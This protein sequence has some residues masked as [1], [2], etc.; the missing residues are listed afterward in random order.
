MNVTRR[1]LIVAGG[2]GAATVSVFVVNALLARAWDLQTFGRFSAVWI[3]GNALAPVFQ[4]GIPSAL[5][6]FFPRHDSRGR[7]RLLGMA[8]ASLLLA[9]AVFALV[10]S[11]AG[12]ALAP[13]LG[14]EQTLTSGLIVSFLPYAFCLVAAGQTDSALI[15][16]GAPVMQATIGGAHALSLIA[17][18]G[19][20]CQVGLAVEEVL[21]LA[22][23]TGLARLGVCY[24]TLILIIGVP[25]GSA[26]QE[27]RS[28]FRYAWTIGTGDAMGSLSRNVD[29]AVVLSLF[30]A[31][32][33]GLYHVGAIEVPVS[34]LLSAVVAVVLPEVSRLAAEGE[35]TRV[36][37][38]FRRAVGQLAMLI[39]PLFCYL[40]VFAENIFAVYLPKAFAES[41][42]VF[43]L[44]LLALPLRCAIY[45]P[46]LV[47][48][49]H[50][51]WALKGA[52]F[53][54]VTNV[55]LSI[56]FVVVL[57]DHA[58]ELAL[59]GPAA[60]TVTA[61]YLQV[62]ALVIATSIALGS[63]VRAMLPGRRLLRT[64]GVAV[65]SAFT[66]SVLLQSWQTHALTVVAIS[67]G[68]FSLLYCGGLSL[69]A[70]ERKEL[71]QVW[72]SVMQG[73]HRG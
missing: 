63:S 57:L 11:L 72:H 55:V 32:S 29:R 53:D 31:G 5:L 47:G 17:V 13:I 21:Q 66:V 19:Y 67:A 3:L 73:S 28:F 56:V 9:A 70:A 27:W 23:I 10:L 34:L 36:V 40:F 61:T 41:E 52:L 33:L 68:G 25:L 16:A 18:A 45:N 2:R 14:L 37:R 65:V 49:G 8:G 50:A 22:S 42:N 69:F 71:Q 58:P 64:A 1:V 51:G 26:A 43:R 54:L 7:R 4:Q 30:G 12:P 39:I 59:Y 38:L 15:A 20:A 48:L 24:L 60:A 35:H 62:V 46:S 6:Y 44:F